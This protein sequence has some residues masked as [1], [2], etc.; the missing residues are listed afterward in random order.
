[1]ALFKRLGKVGIG[2]L[3][4]LNSV[5]IFAQPVSESITIRQISNLGFQSVEQI[6]YIKGVLYY[7]QSI[8]KEQSA[9]SLFQQMKRVQLRES[10]TSC[11]AGSLEVIYQSSQTIKQ[12]G[13]LSGEIERSLIAKLQELRFLVLRQGSPK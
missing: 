4:L 2:L 3:I 1:M 12:K 11:F 13:C 9:L 7:N 10:S 8:T 6:K 5:P